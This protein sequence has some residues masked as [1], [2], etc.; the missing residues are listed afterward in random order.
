MSSRAGLDG[1]RKSCPH[2]VAIPTVLP[3]LS[4]VRRVQENETGLELNGTHELLACAVG[5]HL[6][7][8]YVCILQSSTGTL[9]DTSNEA[10]L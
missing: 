6:L 8:K 1:C 10:G 9:L 2:W 3:Q 4:A 5:V 7:G